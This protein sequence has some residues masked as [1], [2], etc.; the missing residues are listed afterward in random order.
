MQ[1]GPGRNLEDLAIYQ[2]AMQFV[3]AMYG[4]NA[5]IPKNDSYGL[6]K[7]MKQAAVGVTTNIGE[8]SK[9]KNQSDKTRYLNL[10]L[11]SLEECRYYLNFVEEVGYARTS[12][13]KHHLQQVRAILEDHAS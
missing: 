13:L 2:K 12:D 5:I 11:D 4:L 7:L 1:Q 3:M 9:K 6:A 10:A 8:S